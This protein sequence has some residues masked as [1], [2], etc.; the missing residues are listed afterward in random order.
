[1]VSVA[2]TEYRE[3]ALDVPRYPNVIQTDAAVNPG[4]SGGPLLDLQGRLV[5]VTS[6]VRTLSPDGRIVQGQNYAIGVDRVRQVTRVLRTGRS[7]GWAG[8]GFSY[9]AARR[10]EPV[11]LVA[12]TS[13]PGI[14]SG[15]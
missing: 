11:G 8:L 6:A 15:S 12:A 4:N 7:I 2:R 14:A 3:Y 10:D 13:A 9:P 5:G 1:V